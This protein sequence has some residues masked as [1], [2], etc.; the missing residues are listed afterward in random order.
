[1]AASNISMDMDDILQILD[2][3]GNIRKRRLLQRANID[4]NDYKERRNISVATINED[5][6]S[7]F[8]N[9]ADLLKRL[10]TKIGA[11]GDQQKLQSFFLKIL[12]IQRISKHAMVLEQNEHRLKERFSSK[13]NILQEVINIVHKI[14]GESNVQDEIMNVVKYLLDKDPKI[15][16]NKITQA[17]ISTDLI[18]IIKEHVDLQVAVCVTNIFTCVLF[19]FSMYICIYIVK[20]ATRL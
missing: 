2:D 3:D 20:T 7:N 1:M 16:T 4:E 5:I 13:A 12:A 10:D 19:P 9:N 17:Q 6:Q 18:D 14:I 15:K 8:K 11:K